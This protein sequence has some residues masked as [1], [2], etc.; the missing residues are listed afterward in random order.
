MKQLMLALLFVASM[1]GM[2]RLL[3]KVERARTMYLYELSCES[4]F[5]PYGTNI[6]ERIQ[7]RTMLD[8][9]YAQG[10]VDFDLVD[11]LRQRGAVTSAE[12]S[13]EPNRGLLRASG[14]MNHIV[15]RRS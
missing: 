13:A 14:L 15:S 3:M 7:G 4:F 5:S 9:V 12:L 10:P 8:L 1:N 6:N 2:D 11:Y